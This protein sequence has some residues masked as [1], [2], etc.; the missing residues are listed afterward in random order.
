[1][2]SPTVTVGAK[3]P[4]TDSVPPMRPVLLL[5]DTRSEDRSPNSSTPGETASLAAIDSEAVAPALL[6]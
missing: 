1:M 5:I 4:P 6:V 3:E 2:P